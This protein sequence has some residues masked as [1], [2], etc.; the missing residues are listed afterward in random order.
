[1]PGVGAAVAITQETVRTQVIVVWP[2]LALDDCLRQD[3][4]GHLGQDRGLEDALRPQEGYALAFE[5]ESPLENRERQHL[6]VQPGLLPP[7]LEGPGPDAPGDIL[8]HA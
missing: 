7:E 4:E 6:A 1:M 5:L 8:R 3:A 2:G